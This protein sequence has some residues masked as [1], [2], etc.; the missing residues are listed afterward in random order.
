MFQLKLLLA[1]KHYNINS[2]KKK[3]PRSICAKAKQEF[4]SLKIQGNDHLKD[5]ITLLFCNLL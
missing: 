1:R 5:N 4:D 3:L 2:V